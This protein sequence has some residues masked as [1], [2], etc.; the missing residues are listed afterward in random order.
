MSNLARAIATEAHAAQVDKADAPYVL[1]PLRLMQRMDTDE[2]KMVAVLHDVVEDG[3]GWSFE[4]LKAEGFSETVIAALRC[5]TKLPAD[6]NDYMAFI[7][8]AATNAVARKVKPADL[9]DN[10]DVRRIAVLTE[11]DLKRIDKYHRAWRWLREQALLEVT[12]AAAKKAGTALALFVDEL[13]YVEEDELAALITALH[14]S[15]QRS[16]PVVLVGAGLPQLP[17]RWAGPSLTRNA[18]SIFQRS[19]RYPRTLPARRSPSRRWIRV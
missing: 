4:R 19:G 16:L 9:E 2:E 18:C 14:R 6:E 11:Q 12:G 5:V 10:L 15:A 3:P 8:R 13:Q 1:H 17:A 7:R